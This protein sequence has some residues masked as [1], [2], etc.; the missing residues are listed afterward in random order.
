M[1]HSHKI[2]QLHILLNNVLVYK[3]KKSQNE[4]NTSTPMTRTTELITSQS[5]P[6]HNENSLTTVAATR[7]SCVRRFLTLGDGNFS[8]SLALAKQLKSRECDASFQLTAT[9][10]D[11]YDELVEKYPEFPRICAQLEELGVLVLHRVDATNLR[12]SLIAAGGPHLRFD[13]IV[14]NHPHC[15]EENIQRHQSLL[16][17]FYTSALQVL[18]GSEDDL[19]SELFL[20]LAEGQSERWQ[21]VERGS[22]AGYRLCRKISD[23]DNNETFGLS[24][25]RKRHQNGKSFHQVTLRGETKMQTSTLLIFRRQNCVQPAMT[26]VREAD[27]SLPL[28]L[29]SMPRKRKAESELPLEFGCT[30]CTRSFKSAQGLRTH[31]H[32]V[33]ELDGEMTTVAQLPCNFCERVFKKEEDKRQHQLAKHGKDPLIKPDWY[34]KQQKIDGA[35]LI[36]AARSELSASAATATSAPVEPHTCSICHFSFASAVEFDAHWY[37]LQPRAALKRKCLI[38]NR[39]FD[40]ERALRQHQ[41]FCEVRS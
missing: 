8:Y 13:T 25:E 24:Y 37:N 22:L 7:K 14:F 40:E 30:L 18:H 21:A 31:I 28:L 34:K 23:V 9:S 3:L 41:N 16:S 17:H 1:R 36:T 33:H 11:T 10:Y 32:M 20:A 12:E 27:V 38:C 35:V 2:S 39:E 4:I 6:E 19:E 29:T 5:I 15:G 26:D